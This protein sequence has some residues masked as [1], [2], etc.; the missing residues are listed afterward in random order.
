MSELTS[1]RG[2][3]MLGYLPRYYEASR[4]MR[5]SLQSRGAEFDEL[6]QALDEALD[7]FFVDTA[8]WGLDDWEKELE[9]PLAPAQ[10]EAERRDKVRSRL[11]GY[12]T[13][14]I[15][16]VKQVAEAYDKGRCRVVEDFPVYTLTVRFVDTTGIPSNLDDL[17]AAVRAVVPAHLDLE[18]EL[19]YLVWDELDAKGWTWDQLDAL[20]LTWDAL[21]VFA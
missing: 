15:V 12:G 3:V 11:R 16:L 18:Y 1:P 14:T 4:V 17:K 7:Q 8:T 19:N 20:G 6:R 5:E 2:L 21:E 10:P 13:A 9:L